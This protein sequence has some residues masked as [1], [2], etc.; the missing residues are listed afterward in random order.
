MD[1][2][3]DLAFICAGSATN[4]AASEAQSCGNRPV[5]GPGEARGN[6]WPQLLRD[7]PCGV[8]AAQVKSDRARLRSQLVCAMRPPFCAVLGLLGMHSLPF[9]VRRRLGV[10]P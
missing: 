6:G 5:I 9:L 3:R 8:S 1:W 4:A 2:R 7:G 10:P